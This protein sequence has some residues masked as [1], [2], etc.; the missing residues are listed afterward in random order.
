[1]FKLCYIYYSGQRKYCG[2]FVAGISG[3]AEQIT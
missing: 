2:L 1:M 3:G